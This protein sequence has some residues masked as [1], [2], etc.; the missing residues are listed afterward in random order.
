MSKKYYN[1]IL[2]IVNKYDSHQ[3]LDRI[4][5]SCTIPIQ[6]VRGTL[7]GYNLDTNKIELVNPLYAKFATIVYAY[8]TKPITSNTQWCKL[9]KFKYEQMM[10]QYIHTRAV[11]T[12]NILDRTLQDVFKQDYIHVFVSYNS[13]MKNRSL[14]AVKL[15]MK[16]LDKYK[17]GLKFIK[18]V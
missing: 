17:I 1:Y 12:A 8:A 3:R 7:L 16:N 6:K 2:Y 10:N 5:V 15:L 11:Y 18:Y 13:S 14:C 9:S 4:F